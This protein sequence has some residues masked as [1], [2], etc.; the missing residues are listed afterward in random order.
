MSKRPRTD[1]CW[2]LSLRGRALGGG[3]SS[4]DDSEDDVAPRGSD[5]HAPVSEDS[6]LLGELDLA[7]RADTAAYK[8][9]PWSIAKANATSRSLKPI[10][11]TKPQPPTYSA[12][13]AVKTTM[14]DLLRS[15]HSMK[16]RTPVENHLDV[17]DV[18][19]LPKAPS[20]SSRVSTYLDSDFEAH[21]PSDET[22][23]DDSNQL[24][25]LLKDGHVPQNS[26]KDM[27]PYTPDHTLTLSTTDVDFSASQL[28]RHDLP[29]KISLTHTQMAPSPTVRSSKQDLR[30][31]LF[32]SHVKKPASRNDLTKPQEASS[33][34]PEMSNTSAHFRGDLPVVA[35]VHAFSR[36]A[37][38][39]ANC[40]SWKRE[41][42]SPELGAFPSSGS[43]ALDPSSSPA[44]SFIPPKHESSPIPPQYSSHNTLPMRNAVPLAH[45]HRVSPY[46]SRIP[47]HLAFGPA[48][49]SVVGHSGDTIPHQGCEKW[50]PMSTNTPLFETTSSPARLSTRT[51]K[52]TDLPL[53]TSG[54]ELGSSAH[55]DP[56]Y[57]RLTR[58]P[59]SPSYSPR[60]RPYS[61]ANKPRGKRDAYNAFS[62][63]EASW[64]TLPTKKRDDNGGRVRRE[65]AVSGCFKLPTL[66]KPD[67][68]KRLGQTG[69]SARNVTDPARGKRR[70]TTYLPPPLQNPTGSARRSEGHSSTTTGSDRSDD[71]GARLDNSPFKPFTIRRAVPP[72]MSLSAFKASWPGTASSASPVVCRSGLP[73]NEETHYDPP[74]HDEPPTILQFDTEGLPRRYS[75]VRLRAAE[76]RNLLHVTHRIVVD[77]VLAVA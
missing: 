23:V 8:P 11:S 65:G 34:Y 16:T 10:L 2:S 28:V 22:L 41:W 58:C 70:V 67:S 6:R 31:L 75:H 25:A 54:C 68:K 38:T 35:G 47:D 43:K 3:F 45:N 57:S 20:T 12:S 27:A 71:P 14:L 61:S 59:S 50:E 51:G 60:T 66:L 5:N 77:G 33:S 63:P 4:E 29:S 37:P 44:A 74:I 36:I 21:T 52:P 42:R 15:N 39:R 26:D 9:N 48:Q 19:G 13:K 46:A 76:V 30:S 32:R 7:S 1:A 69:S 73:F 64:S 72:T 24:E 18:P 49:Q 17:S 53:H 62:S 40:P 56:V 55:P